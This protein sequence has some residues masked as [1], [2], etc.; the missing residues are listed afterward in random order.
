LQIETGLGVNSILQ[1]PSYAF[2]ISKQKL[3]NNVR[4]LKTTVRLLC[5]SHSHEGW[6][7][8]SAFTDGWNTVWRRC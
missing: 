5:T 3:S 8:S 2:E 1:K 6:Y 7:C 4:T